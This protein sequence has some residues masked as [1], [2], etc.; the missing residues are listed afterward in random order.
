MKYDCYYC[1]SYV[2]H[3]DGGVCDRCESRR[4]KELDEIEKEIKKAIT[5]KKE[6]I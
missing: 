5:K 3:E 1:G 2:P 4:Y 6:E